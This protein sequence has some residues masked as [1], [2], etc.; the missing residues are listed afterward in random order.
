MKHTFYIILWIPFFL[1]CG[2]SE[3]FKPRS[4]VHVE[5][6]KLLQDTLLNVRAIELDEERVNC[7]SFI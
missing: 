7:V 3:R 6:K 5:I 4:Y 2:K 1:F